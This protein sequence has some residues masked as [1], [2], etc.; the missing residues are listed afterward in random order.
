MA[1]QKILIVDDSK[2][3]RM[4]I[5]EMLPKGNFEVLEAKD[6]IEGLDV[7]SQT[8]PQLILLDFFMPRMNGWE[9]VQKLR[10]NPRLQTIPVVMMSGRREDVETAVPELFTYFE[11]INKPFEQDVLIQA[12]RAATSKA[13]QR[14][15]SLQAASAG[16]PPTASPATSTASPGKAETATL[17]ARVERLE[18]ENAALRADL[19]AVKKQTLQIMTFIKQRM[20]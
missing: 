4:Q 20:K 6:G 10:E 12:I 13:K 8:H 11:F 9:V 16:A 7:V 17:Q 5:R 18:R 3:I 14:Q 19:E 15:Q 2:T 1:T